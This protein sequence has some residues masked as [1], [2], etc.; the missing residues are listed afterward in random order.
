MHELAIAQ[1][2]VK[3]VEAQALVAGAEHVTQVNVSLGE[4]SHVASDSLRTYFEMLTSSN[5]SP[6]RDASLVVKRVP[7]R[8][9]CEACGLEYPAQT[10]VKCPTCQRPGRLTDPGDQLLLESLE[11]TP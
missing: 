1:H 3:L 5:G 11:V 7:M 4:Q 6:A 2:L 8:F 9:F 10:H